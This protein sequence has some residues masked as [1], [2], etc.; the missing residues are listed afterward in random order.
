MI[1]RRNRFCANHLD[2]SKPN[3]QNLLLWRIKKQR[4]NYSKGGEGVADVGAF[5]KWRNMNVLKYFR[6]FI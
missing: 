2:C 4:S 1:R 5:Q 3:A 6:A